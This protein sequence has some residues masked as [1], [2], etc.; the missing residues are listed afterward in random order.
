MLD[1]RAVNTAP[2][3]PSV[4]TQIL[5]EKMDEQAGKDVARWDTVMG[6]LDL[7]FAKVGAIDENQQKM[8][9]KFDLS[10]GVIEQMIKDQQLM[11]KQIEA[12]GQAVA[13]LTLNQ[14]RRR[15]P[16]PPSPT[17][18]EAT[19]ENP[20]HNTRRLPLELLAIIMCPTTSN[21][22]I[23]VIDS[24]LANFFPK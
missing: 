4:R 8:E 22:E 23:K 24:P 7:L 14:H 2:P 11:A 15:D 21:R 1:L 12:I 6:S 19:M 3:K 16:S 5:L 18:S 13:H 9:A 10:T 17:S 20:F